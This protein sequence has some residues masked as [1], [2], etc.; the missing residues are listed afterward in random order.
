MVK[1]LPKSQNPRVI[2]YE[3]I[4]L[5]TAQSKSPPGRQSVVTELI[6]LDGNERVMIFAP[7]TWIG[8]RP[9]WSIF[10]GPANQSS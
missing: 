8:A 9:E 2:K 5:K 10:T 3:L 6:K 4:E 7:T 1:R